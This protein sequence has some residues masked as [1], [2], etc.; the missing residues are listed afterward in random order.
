MIKRSSPRRAK[1]SPLQSLKSIKV[2]LS[3]GE[4]GQTR[5]FLKL[6]LKQN[7]F[8]ISHLETWVLGIYFGKHC[9]GWSRLEGDQAL[10]L[11]GAGPKKT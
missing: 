10:V 3:W 6:I 5:Q 8:L 1:V 4:D 11:E 2:N 9:C 7:P